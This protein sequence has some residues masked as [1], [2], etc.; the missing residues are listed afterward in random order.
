MRVFFSYQ[1]ISKTSSSKLT[2]QRGSTNPT[3]ACSTQSKRGRWTRHRARSQCK[4]V[5]PNR[6][7]SDQFADQLRSFHVIVVVMQE[8]TYRP[9][10]DHA[11]ER[12]DRH[13]FV[14][15]M[16]L[17]RGLLELVPR[18]QLLSLR[19]TEEATATPFASGGMMVPSLTVCMTCA[20]D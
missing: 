16:T 13:R 2:Q 5:D 1:L 17:L 18:R 15:S 8:N 9:S 20:F 11:V 12:R 10:I 14:K 19:T 4:A 6:A 7:C 3:A